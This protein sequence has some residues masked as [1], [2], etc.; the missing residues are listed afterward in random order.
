MLNLRPHHR[1][2]I[3]NSLAIFA[4]LLL[5]VS[6]FAGFQTRQEANYSG[7]QTTL[8]TQAEKTESDSINNAT[9]TR[10]SGLKLDFLLFRH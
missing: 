3:P 2:R 7:L 4:V 1:V 5:L 8:S 10:S 9:K 6:G